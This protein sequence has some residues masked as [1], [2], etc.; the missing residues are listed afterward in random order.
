MSPDVPFKHSLVYSR[1]KIDSLVESPTQHP[2]VHSDGKNAADTVL[3]GDARL[4][5][6]HSDKEKKVRQF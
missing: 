2:E 6:H 1:N 4:Q 5:L 3:I